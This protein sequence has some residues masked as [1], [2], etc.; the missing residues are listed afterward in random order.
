MALVAQLVRGPTVLFEW[1][2]AAAL[3][4]S[5]WACMWPSP[6][7]SLLQAWQVH[8]V[9]SCHLHLPPRPA[10][11]CLPAVQSDAGTQQLLTSVLTPE[12]L[13]RGAWRERELQTRAQVEAAGAWMAGPGPPIQQ[14]QQTGVTPT[15]CSMAV[16]ISQATP[17]SSGE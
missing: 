13:L 8:D 16:D 17:A 12:Q 5:Q 3:C 4:D 6:F 1:Q 11:T 2:T 9:A 15:C 7:W 10:D 14:R